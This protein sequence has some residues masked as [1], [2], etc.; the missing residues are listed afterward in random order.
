MVTLGAK[1]AWFRCAAGSGG[2]PAYDVETIDTTGAGDAFMGAA[3][4]RLGN[5]SLAELKA[6][7]PDELAG[8]IDFAN[9]AGSLTTTK[10]GAIPALPGLSEIENCRKKLRGIK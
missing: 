3:L 6:I 9:A 1:G 5:K 8:V 4:Y 2:L 10:K 7:S